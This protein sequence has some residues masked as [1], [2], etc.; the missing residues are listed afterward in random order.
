MLDKLIYFASAESGMPNKQ[1]DRSTD[2]GNVNRSKIGL[3]GLVN[4]VLHLLLLR[5]TA[6]IDRVSALYKVLYPLSLPLAVKLYV[7]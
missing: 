7:Q 4:V 1:L 2:N 5:A 6:T 3:L